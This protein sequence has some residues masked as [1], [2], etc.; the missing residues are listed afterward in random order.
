MHSALVWKHARTSARVAGV[1]AALCLVPVEYTIEAVEASLN[2]LLV[3]WIF[4]MAMGLEQVFVRFDEHAP[5]AAVAMARFAGLLRAWDLSEVTSLRDFRNLAEALWC[6]VCVVICFNVKQDKHFVGMDWYRGLFYGVVNAE[7]C[8]MI[9]LLQAPFEDQGWFA[10][11]ALAFSAL[12][13]QLYSRVPEDYMTGTRAYL[14]CFLPVLF[15]SPPVAAAF[16][17]IAGFILVLEDETRD[18]NILPEWPRPEG[19]HPVDVI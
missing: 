16:S 2:I 18:A 4:C 6:L 7:F 17:L 13:A 3:D 1:T 10:L 12:C 15:V 14:V 19:Y 11:R 5:A 9:M 8:V